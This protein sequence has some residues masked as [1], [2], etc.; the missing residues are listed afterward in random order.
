MV[1]DANEKSAREKRRRINSFAELNS[2]E[3]ANNS[4]FLAREKVEVDEF[5]RRSKPREFFPLPSIV[6]F[7]SL[8]RTRPFSDNLIEFPSIFVSRETRETENRIFNVNQAEVVKAKY[9]FFVSKSGRLYDTPR[10]HPIDQ[11]L[12]NLFFFFFFLLIRLGI[13][14]VFGGS[15]RKISWEMGGG[16]TSRSIDFFPS[17]LCEHFL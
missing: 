11:K 7:P 12:K 15:I 8:E 14:P 10:T 13:F 6:P 2:E 1:L 16:R 3:T 17:A 4:S 5:S 9:R